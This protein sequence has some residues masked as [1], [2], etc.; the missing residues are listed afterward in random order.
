[1]WRILQV[2]ENAEKKIKQKR[3]EE[4]SKRKRERKENEKGASTVVIS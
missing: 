4:N 1:M 3:N 2:E